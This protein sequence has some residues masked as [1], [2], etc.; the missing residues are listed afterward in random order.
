MRHL[1]RRDD[2]GFSLIEILIVVAI[3]G[4]IATIV[5]PLYVNFLTRARIARAES[6]VKAIV[7]AVI[8]FQGHMEGALPAALSTL[9]QAATNPQGQTA[10][11]FLGQVPVPP[12]GWTASYTYTPD[13][14][15][16]TFTV[17]ASGDG[18]TLSQP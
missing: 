11:P 12:A 18:T 5:V 2:R 17:R 3:V 13:T 10:G 8:V 1:R 6:D 7:S 16:G 15:T 14:A 9:T 4:V